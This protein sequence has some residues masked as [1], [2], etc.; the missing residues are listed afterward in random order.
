MIRTVF[1]IWLFFGVFISGFARTLTLDECVKLARENYPSVAQY[2]LLDKTKQL[3]FAN[4]AKVWLP[5][6]SVGAQITWQNEVAALPDVL[7]GILAQNGVSYPGLGKTQYC[8][9]TA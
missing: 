3:N 5:Q 9:L 2:G 8:N 1:A 6:G 4:I 7:T